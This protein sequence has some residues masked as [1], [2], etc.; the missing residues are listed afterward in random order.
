[1]NTLKEPASA[2]TMLE[3]F[4]NDDICKK[5]SRKLQTRVPSHSEKGTRITLNQGDINW[6]LQPM[7]GAP[8]HSA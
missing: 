5:C 3:L 1:M 4:L 8:S 2:A 7:A 6:G